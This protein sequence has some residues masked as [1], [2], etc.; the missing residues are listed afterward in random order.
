MSK[1]LKVTVIILSMLYVFL[2]FPLPNTAVANELTASPTEFNYK[3]QVNAPEMSDEELLEYYQ[4][5]DI[6]ITSSETG[7]ATN[8]LFSNSDVV[9]HLQTK[10]PNYTWNNLP[11][12]DDKGYV[13]D[14]YYGNPDNVYESQTEI[15]TAKQNLNIDMND[16]VGCGSLAL[17]DQMFYLAEYAGYTFLNNQTVNNYSQTTAAVDI[18]NNRIHIATDIFERTYGITSPIAE[19]TFT[20]PNEII[21]SANQIFENHGYNKQII[22]Y[23]D[24]LPNLSSATTKINNIVDSIDN[25]MPVIWWTVG[26]TIGKFSNHYMNIFGYEYWTG[27]DNS[28]NQLKHLM[29]TLN[30]NWS[31]RQVVY[32]DSDLLKTATCGFIYFQELYDRMFIRPID[33]NYECAYNVAE[34][35][36]TISVK[37]GNFVT[38]RLRTGLI[39]HYDST[40]TVIDEQYITTSAYKKD[41][42]I[43]YLKY[44]FDR[45][46]KM[47][48]LELSWWGDDEKITASNGTVHVRYTDV[49]DNLFLG[50]DLLS[51]DFTLSCNPHMPSKIHVEFPLET[52][53]LIVYVKANEPAGSRNK[54]RLVIGNIDVIFA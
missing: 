36:Q 6:F 47:V 4:E 3:Y 44:T 17:A 26:N 8:L 16:Y 30:Y 27:V 34:I 20:P 13:S 42:G 31:S 33:Y 40:N 1:V 49:H 23:G 22:A 28:G 12:D 53:T 52:D 18:S 25:G 54:G 51:E 10:Y 45:P 2:I 38:T 7:S 15:S 14:V 50:K 24:I 37:M 46:I 32:M 43:A 35:S 9:S 48:N 19:G 29:F 5:N 41:A 39:N 11:T 21:R